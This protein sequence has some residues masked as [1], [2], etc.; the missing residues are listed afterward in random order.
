[1]VNFMRPIEVN[2]RPDKIEIL[3]WPGP[4]PPLNPTRLASGQPVTA[5]DY[6]NRRIGDFL[7]E[8]KLTE[9]RGTGF[10]KIRKAM[11]RNGSPAPIFE[12]DADSHYFLTVLP[13]HPEASASFDSNTVADALKIDL[14]RTA[15]KVLRLCLAPQSRHDIMRFLELSNQTHNYRRHLE[16]LMETG[17]LAFEHEAHVTH[18]YQRYTT[19]KKGIS[20]LERTEK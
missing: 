1:M 6:R 4:L 11:A 18:K 9:G 12:T 7:K 17:L 16:P 14:P 8:L 19:T 20:Y 5:K 10:P 15:V 13:V 3:S 2:V